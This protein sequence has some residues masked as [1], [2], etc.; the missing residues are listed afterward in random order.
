MSN[1]IF[2]QRIIDGIEVDGVDT[3]DYPD[4]CDAYIS[5]AVYADTGEELDEEELSTLT[6]ENPELVNE[7]A[8]ESCL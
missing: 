2:R 5:R 7:M 6:D 8:I 4:F 1:V 3:K